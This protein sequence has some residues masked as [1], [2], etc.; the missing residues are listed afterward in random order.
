MLLKKISR[1][2]MLGIQ[3]R[4]IK[5]NPMLAVTRE[6]RPTP[7]MWVLILRYDEGFPRPLGFRKYHFPNRWES[8]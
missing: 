6:I 2:E 7:Y 4:E 3:T 8:A 5:R 1:E